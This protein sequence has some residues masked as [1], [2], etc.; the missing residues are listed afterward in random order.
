MKRPP[1]FVPRE[2]DILGGLCLKGK[3]FTTIP[4]ESTTTL[5]EKDFF[6]TIF[7]K[8]AQKMRSPGTNHTISMT[9]FY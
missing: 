4:D 7:Q 5:K 3:L 2:E 9:L 8:K 6:T 1:A